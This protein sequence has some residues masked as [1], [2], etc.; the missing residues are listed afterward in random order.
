MGLSGNWVP[1]DL[2]VV[3][4]TVPYERNHEFNPLRGLNSSFSR[5]AFVWDLALSCS[6]SSTLLFPSKQ[7]Q[8]FMVNPHDLQARA[9]GRSSP[10]MEPRVGTLEEGVS[11][12]ILGDTI[13]RHVYIIQYKDNIQK[14]HM[15]TYIYNQL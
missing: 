8:V 5:H 3:D 2:M 12:P 6:A 13:Y 15:C 9:H 7:S 14:L 1:P 4:R 11:Y 10:L